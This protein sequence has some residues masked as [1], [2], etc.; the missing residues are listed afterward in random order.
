MAEE[1]KEREK[2]EIED[3]KRDREKE[4]ERHTGR[5]RERDREKERERVRE[6]DK[7]MRMKVDKRPI[8]EG[9]DVEEEDAFPFRDGVV[10]KK[11]SRD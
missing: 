4:R 6:G 1:T 7:M 10:K 11:A 8:M 5:E 3:R 2:R 9:N